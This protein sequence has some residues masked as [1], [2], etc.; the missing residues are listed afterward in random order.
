VFG[1]KRFNSYLFEH[2]FDLVMDHKL[3]L[4]LLNEHCSASPQ[5]SVRI[6]QWSQFLLG[7]KYTMVFRNIRHVTM[8]MRYAGCLNYYP[9]N[10]QTPP[11]LVLLKENLAELP[12]TAHHSKLWTCRDPELSKILQVIRHRWPE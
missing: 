6:K 9:V 4:A 11:K 5:A 2:H 3:L 7:N 12:V 1:I 8:Q 10:T